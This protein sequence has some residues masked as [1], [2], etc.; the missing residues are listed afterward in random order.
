MNIVKFIECLNDHE[1]S[2]F[3]GILRAMDNGKTRITDV[4]DNGDNISIRL[5]NVLT[6]LS[7][8]NEYMEDMTLYDLLKTRN[9][10]KVTMKEFFEWMKT[11]KFK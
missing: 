11:K 8:N 1:V 10:G 7:R 3:R 5:Y 2:M 4:I 6:T 9:C